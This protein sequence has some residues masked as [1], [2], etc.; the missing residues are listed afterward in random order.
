MVPIPTYQHITVTTAAPSIALITLKRPGKYNAFTNQMELDLVRAFADLDRDESVRAIVVTGDGKAFCAGADL[1]EGVLERMAGEGRK[2]HRDQGGRVALAIHRCR[3][4][5]IAAL[6]G[7]AVGV[8]VT[9]ILPMTIRVAYSN[10]KVGFVFSQRG[11]VMEAASSFF[12]PRLIGHSRAL[13][14]TTTGSVLPASSPHFGSLFQ[15]LLPSS[16]A[17]LP[18]AVALASQISAQTSG[19]STY[20]MREMMWRGKDSAEETHLLDSELMWD[21][22]GGKDKKE[23]IASFLEKRKAVFGGV[24]EGVPDMVPWW[25]AADTRKVKE[26]L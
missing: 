9:M 20:L 10:A 15:E 19:T 11:L 2:E 3:K 8:G 17:V 14:L 5:T 4:P 16:E 26:K 1:D 25:G 12:L 22:Y 18:R 7:S 24:E 13:Y 21:L 23:G 6:N